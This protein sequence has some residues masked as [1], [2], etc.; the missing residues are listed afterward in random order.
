MNNVL[1]VPSIKKNLLSSGVCTS[2]GYIITFEYDDAN[3]YSKN[4]VV[5]AQ[6][7]KQVS[8]LIRMPIKSGI[9][10]EA[11]Y[12]LSTPLKVCSR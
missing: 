8:K 10:F 2:N 9:K 1:Y 12:A 3:I 5:M 6:G 7:I 4:H 11:N